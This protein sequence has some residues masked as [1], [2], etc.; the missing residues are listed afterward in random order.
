VCVCV[1]VYVCVSVCMCVSVCVEM[2]PVWLVLMAAGL[3][4]V[5]DF[6]PRE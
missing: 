2:R 1:L 5:R 3:D 6:I 4:S